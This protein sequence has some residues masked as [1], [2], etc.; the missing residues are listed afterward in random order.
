MVPCKVHME[1]SGN[2]VTV[3]GEGYVHALELEGEYV[4]S[5]NYFSLLPGEKRTVT[6][7]PTKDAVGEEITVTGYTV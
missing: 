6:C 2:S 3:W 5:D 4:F 7:R 1:R